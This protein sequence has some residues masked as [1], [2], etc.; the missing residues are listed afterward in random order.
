MAA[1]RGV[2]PPKQ[3]L[4]RPSPFFFP[5]VSAAPLCFSLGTF[6][7]ELESSRPAH[8]WTEAGARGLW[9]RQRVPVAVVHPITVGVR[10]DLQHNL[11]YTTV[12]VHWQSL[13]AGN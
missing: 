3:Q 8:R 12:V 4:A 10:V 7:G 5:L 6:S 2:V 11:N 13:A 9:G 1:L